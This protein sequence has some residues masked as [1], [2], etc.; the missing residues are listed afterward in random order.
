MAGD[1]SDLDHRIVW[2]IAA[3]VA[4]LCAVLTAALVAI[5][6]RPKAISFGL[7]VWMAFGWVTGLYLSASFVALRPVLS[8]LL[9]ERAMEYHDAGHGLQLPIVIGG[10]GTWAAVKAIGW[11]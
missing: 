1:T 5:A 11:I 7:H 3:I 4:G 10:V 2:S 9:S 6:P 8:R